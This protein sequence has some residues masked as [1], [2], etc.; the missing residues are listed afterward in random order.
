MR[1]AAGT[2]KAIDRLRPPVI[3][4][5]KGSRRD[6]ITW[7]TSDSVETTSLSRLNIIQQMVVRCN[8]APATDGTIW[9]PA[10]GD[11]VTGPLAKKQRK[12]VESSRAVGWLRSPQVIVK[13]LPQAEPVGDKVKGVLDEVLKSRWT[14]VCEA[15]TRRQVGGTTTVGEHGHRMS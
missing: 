10:D 12:D 11:G 7:L 13:L 15:L 14:E 9:L 6:E 4:E 3:S 1:D 2:H 8:T 5:V